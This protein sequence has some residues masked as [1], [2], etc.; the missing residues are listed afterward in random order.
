MN[1]KRAKSRSKTSDAAASRDRPHIAVWPDTAELIKA[2]EG[3]DDRARQRLYGQA[4]AL[5]A[6]DGALPEPLLS[7]ARDGLSSKAMKGAQFSRG[8]PKGTGGAIRKLVQ[9]MLRLKANRALTARQLW[10]V[11]KA[12]PERRRMGIDFSVADSA[13][14]PEHG[15]VSFRRFANIVSEEKKLTG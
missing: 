14:V 9:K 12:L 15:D 1:A 2:A 11:C 6:A 10:D 5:L 4:A 13:W 8:R 7:F 3:G